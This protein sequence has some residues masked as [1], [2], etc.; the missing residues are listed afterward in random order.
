MWGIRATATGSPKLIAY[1]PAIRA[2]APF[3]TPYSATGSGCALSHHH[4]THPPGDSSGY[5]RSSPT[6]LSPGWRGARQPSS[7]GR[8]DGDLVAII[9][10]GV[11]PVEEA[12]VLTC[13]VDVH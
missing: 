9:D 4:R 3:A 7:N 8:Q 11:K 1:E 5:L 12:D 6:A 13:D 10:R 2:S